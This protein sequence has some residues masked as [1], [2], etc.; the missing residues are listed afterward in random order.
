MK[1]LSKKLYIGMHVLIFA[2]VIAFPFLQNLAKC[3]PKLFSGCILHDLLLLYCPFCGGTRATEALLRLDILNA[4]RANA[5]VV[6]FF[7]CFLR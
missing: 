1:Q 7:L 3:L 4:L 6:L 5:F 2:A